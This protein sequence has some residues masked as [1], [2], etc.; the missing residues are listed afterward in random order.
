M[1]ATS[2][3]DGLYP[4][5]AQIEK[6]SIR[7]ASAQDLVLSFSAATVHGDA[8]RLV[9]RAED[10]IMRSCTWPSQM[11]VQTSGTYKLTLSTSQF[12]PKGEENM[13]LEVRERETSKLS[14]RSPVSK[15]RFIKDITVTSTSPE[16]VTFEADLYKGQTLLFRWKNAETTHNPPEVTALM[17][18]WFQRDKRMLAAWQKTVYPINQRTKMLQLYCK[19]TWFKWL[20][21]PQKTSSGPQS[22]YEQCSNGSPHYD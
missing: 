7:E 13:I 17:K 20:E 2:I 14:D 18:D 12:R 21:H 8:L 9:S 22:R 3:A 5:P 16:T 19:L 1:V 11:E 4:P 6:S 10:S 15:F